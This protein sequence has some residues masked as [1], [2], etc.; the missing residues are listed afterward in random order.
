MSGDHLLVLTT[1]PDRQTAEQL[2][3]LLVD[4]SL[5]ACVNILPPMQSIYRWKGKR[6]SGEECQLLIKTNRRQY[7]KLEACI[8]ENH[9]YELPEII[10]IPIEQGH[11][12]YLQ[13]ID[14][15]CEEN[16]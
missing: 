12:Q 13:W 16:E 9:P 5:A 2:A 15:C 6:Q 3:G 7:K 10:A 1:S 8:G 4:Q 14:E 11:P